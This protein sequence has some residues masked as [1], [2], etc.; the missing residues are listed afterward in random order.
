MSDNLSLHMA[1]DRERLV[2]EIPPIGIDTIAKV[3]KQSGI[4]SIHICD[5]ILFGMVIKKRDKKEDCFSIIRSDHNPILKPGVNLS[6]KLN[7]SNL[8]MISNIKGNFNTLIFDQSASTYLFTNGNCTTSIRKIEPQR[9]N[10]FLPECKNEIRRKMDK[11][12]QIAKA[13]GNAESVDILIYDNQISMV[14]IPNMNVFM[15]LNPI[16]TA[17]LIKRKPDIKLRAYFLFHLIADEAVLEIFKCKNV[18][19]LRTVIQL[20]Q[21]ISIEQFE[22]LQ[23]IK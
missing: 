21:D 11:C 20:T 12:K 18:F 17:E 3:I 22:P 19:W 13:K 1:E 23:Q 6:C 5:S 2:A 14:H 9:M 15:S 4:S 10:E 16:A 7:K 8:K